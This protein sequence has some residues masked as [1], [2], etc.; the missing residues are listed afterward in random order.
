MLRRVFTIFK[1]ELPI[2]DEDTLLQLSL[3]A[4]NDIA[5]LDGLVPTL[6]VFGTYPK[7][8]SLFL[9]S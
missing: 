5:G 6:L 4:V 1:A 8:T 3:K 9:P 2:E 7:I